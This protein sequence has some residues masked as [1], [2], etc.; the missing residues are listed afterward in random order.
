MN[1]KYS[2][3]EISSRLLP[4]CV[5]ENE[6]HERISNVTEI[7]EMRIMAT[8]AERTP[9]SVKQFLADKSPEEIGTYFAEHPEHIGMITTEEIHEIEDR[10]WED[11]FQ[12]IEQ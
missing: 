12:T 7:V 1:R 8:I 6:M 11:Y 3:E 4:H 2:A 9:D 5:D 10:T